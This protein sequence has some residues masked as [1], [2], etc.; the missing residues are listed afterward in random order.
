[1]SLLVGI[2]FESSITLTKWFS[3]IDETNDVI[4]NQ[5]E[6]NLLKLRGKNIASNQLLL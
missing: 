5:Q 6:R 4:E 3:E 2:E 1:M